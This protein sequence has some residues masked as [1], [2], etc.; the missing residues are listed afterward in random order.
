MLWLVV[1]SRPSYGE[2]AAIAQ[3]FSG[4]LGPTAIIQS[5][6]GLYA[7]VAGTLYRDKSKQNLSTLKALR[8]I[9]DDAFLSAGTNFNRVVSHSYGERPFTDLMTQPVYKGTVRRMQLVFKQMNIYDGPSDGL[10]GPATVKSFNAYKRVYPGP[11]GDNLDSADIAS[12]EANARDGFRSQAERQAATEMGFQSAE[13]YSAAVIG[14]F[15]SAGI[16]DAARRLGFTRESDY[17]AAQAGG[18]TDAAEFNQAR[19]GGFTSSYEFATAQRAGL[20]SQA[21]YVAFRSSGFSDASAYRAA[22][23]GGFDNKAAFDEASSAGFRTKVDFDAAKAAGFRLA[24]DYV[25]AQDLGLKT[26]TEYLAF[27]TS[28]FSDVAVFRTAK[29][30]GIFSKAAWDLTVA[31]QL[32]A[33][34][35]AANALLADAETFLKMNAS[36]PNLIAIADSAAA[37]SATLR[38]APIEAIQQ[39][40]TKLSAV[41]ASVHGWSDFAAKRGKE[42]SEELATLRSDIKRHLIGRQMQLTKWVA[43]NITSSK[44]PEVV[45]EL[46]LLGEAIPSE[47]LRTLESARSSIEAVILRQN[48]EGD[49]QSTPGNATAANTGGG[50]ERSPFEVTPFNKELLIGPLEGVVILHNAGPTAPSILRTLNGAYSFTNGIATVCL[51]GIDGNLSL[52][53]GLL[54]ALKPMGAAIL[55]LAGT[56]DDRASQKVDLLLIERKKFLEADIKFATGIL[57]ATASGS[58]KTF[59]EIDFL[60]IRARQTVED[61]LAA[62]ISEDVGTGTRSGYGALLLPAKDGAL[63]TVIDGEAKWHSALVNQVVA[64]DPSEGLKSNLS[65]NLNEIYKEARRSKCRILYSSATVLQQ[66][67]QAYD[68]DDLKYEFLPVWFDT[69][70]VQKELDNAAL[71]EAT[72]IRSVEEKR[73]A[74]QA[75][76]QAI[77]RREKEEAEKRAVREADLRREN[78]AA[79][80]AAMNL[81]TDGIKLA[82]L[83]EG[84]GVSATQAGEAFQIA[85]LYP[86]FAMWLN[87]AVRDDWRPLSLENAVS[88]FGK[89]TWKGRSLDAVV[90]ET[91]IK[92]LSRERGEYQNH[93]F[94]LG[95]VIDGEFDM[96]RDPIE[97]ACGEQ[98]EKLSQWKIGHDL[99][100]LW[101]A[102]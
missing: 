6:N 75:E 4:T 63:C 43:A 11:S 58:L 73:L 38:E 51:L 41:L 80:T 21:E 14:G 82:V 52:Q 70:T 95:A 40:S 16:F 100:S 98:A 7:V 79:A 66:V 32:S 42:R 44:L 74:T 8:L 9:P 84:S 85:S 30:K 53:R 60:K 83:K 65:G 91:R 39:A 77:E 27:K 86:D 37:L 23:A 99:R 76:A 67:T 55:T 15:T 96:V 61:R 71:R 3:E 50:S 69:A 68:R 1:S 89:I 5:N 45:G 31:A 25:E 92:L 49:L 22:R 97:A 13:A 59:E 46:K 29:A 24:T 57:D 33:S 34:R 36:A 26:Q 2:A 48:L 35:E 17:R 56:C 64:F 87:E 19:S 54:D 47:D 94:L 88:D 20:S 72:R 10:I 81:F 90:I 12:M 101:A 93:C 18:F 28:G 102:D 78:N 62:E